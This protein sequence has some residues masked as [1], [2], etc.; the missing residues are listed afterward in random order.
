MGHLRLLKFSSIVATNEKKTP[1]IST[2]VM[3][4]KF[5]ERLKNLKNLGPHLC[6]TFSFAFNVFTK[7]SKLGKQLPFGWKAFYMSKKHPRR[8]LKVLQYQI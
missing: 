5:G 3:K 6:V 1:K 7:K 4:E 8:Y 2:F